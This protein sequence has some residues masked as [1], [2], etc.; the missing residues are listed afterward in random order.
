VLFTK[1]YGRILGPG[2]TELDPRLPPEL[3]QRSP[4][5]TAWRALDH[6]STSSSTTG[7]PLPDPET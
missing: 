5:A 1:T 2:L 3:A 7:S 4:L 6:A